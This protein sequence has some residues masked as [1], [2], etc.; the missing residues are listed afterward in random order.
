MRFLVTWVWIMPL[1]F[2]SLRHF[3]NHGDSQLHGL[4]RFNVLTG[5][6]GAGKTN[7]LEAISL[8]APGRGMR[9]ASLS[10]MGA[11]QGPGG[12]AVSADLGDMKIGTG[13]TADMPERRKVRVNGAAASANSLAEW[14]SI[15]WLTPA[16]DRLF[17]ESAGG[18]RQFVDRLVLA[19]DPLHARHASQYE[20]A[21]RER[22]RLLADDIMPD[23]AWLDAVEARMA[24]YGALVAASRVAMIQQ[25]NDVLDSETDKV[26]ARPI[27]ALARGEQDMADNMLETWRNAR[28][29]DRQ[30]KRT[31]D[32]PHRD[33][34]IVTMRQKGQAAALCST[35]EQKAMLIAIILAHSDLVASLKSNAPVLLLDEIAAHLDPVRR[36]VLYDRLSERAGQV[37]MTGTDRALF[38]GITS[39]RHFTVCGGAVHSDN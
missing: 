31:L 8:L 26:F 30:A 20:L 37:W 28:P 23:P 25:L 11:M 21:V 24:E 5:D 6:N 10:E 3:R 27:L 12:F 34:L 15:I 36:G 14:L 9:R 38:S 22:N 39:P 17:M 16:M 7:I 2:L 1:N 29:R 4:A 19:V 33:D 18:R 32:G 13:V 35:G